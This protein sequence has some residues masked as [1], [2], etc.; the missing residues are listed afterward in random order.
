M[1]KLT[2]GVLQ[3]TSYTKSITVE[4]MGE[5]YE[6]DIKPLSNKQASI[7]EALMQKGV[8]VKGKPGIKGRMERVID[9]DTTENTKGRYEA[10]VKTV[11]LGTVDESIT[12]EV[13]ENQ[14]PPK[15]VKEIAKE[16][17]KITGIG[18]Q[19]EIEVFNEGEE[20]PSDES[21]KQ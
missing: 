13:V 17:R 14:F 19:E 9:F 20:N 8:I 6:V 1:K 15:I 11:A 2:A 12:E 18:E 3:G 4:W 5:E 7:I 16:I 10:D 21:R